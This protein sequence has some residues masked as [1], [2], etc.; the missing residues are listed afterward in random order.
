MADKPKAVAVNVSRANLL[1]KVWGFI[2]RKKNNSPK[3]GKQFDNPNKKSL[4][5]PNLNQ[6]ARFWAITIVILILVCG[7]FVF[8][9]TQ[10]DN[11]RKPTDD[12]GAKTNCS[13]QT[14]EAC[15]VLKEA[16]ALLDPGKVKELSVIVEKI[17]KIKGY[18]K[19]PNLLYV[20]LTYYINLSD[21]GN[22]R[23]TYDS[24]KNIYNENVGYDSLLEN[25][26]KPVDLEPIVV[27]L[28]KRAGEV[29]KN[30]YTVPPEPQ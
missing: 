25:A 30:S 29:E 9:N 18:D 15:T 3:E 20:I 8:Y 6:S 14:T 27:F 5:I 10:Q 12:R 13:E 28:E 16:V 26:K 24:L 7:I 17:I 21:G 19:D 22:S 2:T 11:T 1:R 4:K 23:K